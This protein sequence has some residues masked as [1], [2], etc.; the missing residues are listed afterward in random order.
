M[1]LQVH[2]LSLGMAR[3]YLIE[4]QAGLVLVDAGSPGYEGRVLRRMRALERLDL[5][6]I[7]ITHAHLDHYGSAAALRAEGG[8]QVC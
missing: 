5:E 2:G 7:Y 1:S 6:V 4:H 3:A 8:E